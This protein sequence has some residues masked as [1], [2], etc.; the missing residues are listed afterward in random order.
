L[1]E[2]TRQ[3]RRRIFW[4]IPL[5]SFRVIA[6]IHWQAAKLVW[7]RIRYIPK[8]P[9]LPQRLSTTLPNGHVVETSPQT[10]IP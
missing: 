3:T 2:Y 9:Q 1:R 10:L 6:L 5:L 4:Q 8:P 7:K